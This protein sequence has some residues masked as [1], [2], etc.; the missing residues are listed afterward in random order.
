VVFLFDTNAVSDYMNEHPRL[1]TRLA[2]LG[3]PDRAVTCSIVQGEI[4][5][6]VERLPD[7]RRKD[8][9]R[10]KARR[11]F[12]VLRCEPITEA[13]ATCYAVAK[14]SGRGRS[15][16]LDENDLWI[17]ATALTLGATLV[18]RDRDFAYVAGLSVQDW[19]S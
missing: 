8:E 14:H 9:L 6:G 1:K 4:L 10:D 18:S 7:G 11:A 12:S 16:A 5:F 13:A 3:P 19:T 15:G 17:A 2:A